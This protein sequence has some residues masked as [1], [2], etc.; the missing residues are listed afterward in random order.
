MA[1]TGLDGMRRV[2]GGGEGG[3]VSVCCYHETP[4]LG[5]SCAGTSP[6]AKS[7]STPQFR[8]LGSLP[9]QLFRV[10]FFTVS[11]SVV[12]TSLELTRLRT[13][14]GTPPWSVGQSQGSRAD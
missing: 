2:G 13:T 14:P 12:V 8:S 3:C 6:L 10:V 9:A 4:V 5:L 7:L 1:V 11:E